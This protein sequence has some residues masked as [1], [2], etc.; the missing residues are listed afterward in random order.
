VNA[1]RTAAEMVPKAN[2]TV[3][4][5]KTLSVGFWLAGHH[6]SQAVAAGW[7]KDQIS[8]PLLNRIAA[9]SRTIYT[10]QELKNIDQW[11]PHQHMKG[12]LASILNIK[13]LIGVDREKGN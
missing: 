10:L 4:D 13:P 9:S 1:A 5:T 7:T 8:V 12:L 11:R 3:V 6:R 2:V